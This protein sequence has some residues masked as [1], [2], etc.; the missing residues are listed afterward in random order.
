MFSATQSPSSP[1]SLIFLSSAILSVVACLLSGCGSNSG[2]T[3][4]G[5]TIKYD[6]KLLE[7][8]TIEFYPVAGGRSSRTRIL[9]DGSFTLSYKKPGDGLPPGEYKVAVV[10]SKP[11]GPSTKLT[12]PTDGE[13]YDEEAITADTIMI[14]VVPEIYNDISTT[15]LR[16]TITDESPQKVMIEIPKK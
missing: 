8:G 1:N 6:G 7:A 15:P 12:E 14:D 10:S 11:K 13:T 5:G 2:T 16:Q 3:K 9:P 4:A